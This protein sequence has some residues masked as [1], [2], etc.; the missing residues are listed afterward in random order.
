MILPSP[1]RNPE[2]ASE[3]DVELYL[4]ETFARI[5]PRSVLR[6]EL[7]EGG[8]LEYDSRI[9]FQNGEVEI[10]IRRDID[11]FGM[12]DDDESTHVEDP[13]R[14]ALLS[15][16]TR[17]LQDEDTYWRYVKLLDEPPPDGKFADGLRTG[18]LM[19]H[20]WVKFKFDLEERMI[21][22]VDREAGFATRT[23]DEFSELHQPEFMY[24]DSERVYEDE[25]ELI[26]AALGSLIQE[27][28]KSPH[29]DAGG[30]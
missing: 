21:L 5:A 20:R 15:I 23:Q 4:D 18:R 19:L 11:E 1:F 30:S 27:Q 17:A 22:W 28:R 25:F 9:L 24:R 6:T 2:L 16:M 13:C 12:Q 7:D 8:V 3:L 10:I 26:K 29:S 14:Y